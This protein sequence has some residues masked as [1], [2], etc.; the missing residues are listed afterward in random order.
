MVGRVEARYQRVA[1]SPLPKLFPRNVF[2]HVGV[3]TRLRSC[4]I[5]IF[6]FLLKYRANKIRVYKRSEVVTFDNIINIYNI[7][8]YNN[9]ENPI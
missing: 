8:K 3:I 4:F 6:T 7:G 2:K 5:L 1:N 9:I